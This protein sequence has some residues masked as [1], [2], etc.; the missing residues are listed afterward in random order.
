MEIGHML[1]LTGNSTFT[2]LPEADDF[3]EVETLAITHEQGEKICEILGLNPNQINSISIHADGLSISS[4]P[5]AI[6]KR[7]KRK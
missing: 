1:G 7:I 2:P 6:V 5:I 4:P 3:Y